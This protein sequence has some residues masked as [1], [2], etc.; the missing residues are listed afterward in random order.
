MLSRRQL[1]MCNAKDLCPVMLKMHFYAVKVNSKG[2]EL[3]VISKDRKQIS[4]SCSVCKKKRHWC[5]EWQ[6]SFF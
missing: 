2:F 1:V 4:V 3:F 6:Q 5:L